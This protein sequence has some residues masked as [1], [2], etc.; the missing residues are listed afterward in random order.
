MSLPKLALLFVRR[1]RV[2]RVASVWHLGQ[3]HDIDVR[4]AALRFR[5]KTSVQISRGAGGVRTPDLEKPNYRTLTLAGLI[6]IL[7]LCGRDLLRTLHC[8]R[9]RISLGSRLSE[10]ERDPLF[11]R[12]PST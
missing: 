10:D 1:I 5:R 7:F 3:H 4:L 8:V 9:L 12:Y 2:V 6:R 11:L